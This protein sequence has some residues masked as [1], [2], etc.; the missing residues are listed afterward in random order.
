MSDS[1]DN[2]EMKF[3]I[4]N[5]PPLVSMWGP[6]LLILTGFAALALMFSGNKNAYTT[7][8]QIL[9]CIIL[10]ATIGVPVFLTFWFKNEISYDGEEIHIK[11]VFRK[12]RLIFM[13]SKSW[14]MIFMFMPFEVVAHG[15]NL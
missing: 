3:T 11:N 8:S 4:W 6:F 10:T 15:L 7:V 2:K 12:K 5:T 13:R 9:G 1:S 14:I